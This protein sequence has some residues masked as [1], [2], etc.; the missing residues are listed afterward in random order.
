MRGV[1]F[2]ISCEVLVVSG[3]HM[4]AL[5]RLDRGTTTEMYLPGQASGIMCFFG[6][7]KNQI[8]AGGL[9]GIAFSVGVEMEA[10]VVVTLC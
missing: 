2:W 6:K 10:K 4:L 1:F 9:P 5:L 3:Q 8:R 7:D